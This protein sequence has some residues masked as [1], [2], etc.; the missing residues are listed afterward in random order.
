MPQFTISTNLKWLRHNASALIGYKNSNPK[1]N[2]AM[3]GRAV[4][5]KLQKVVYY[6]L[7]EIAIKQMPSASKV[8]RKFQ[9][10]AT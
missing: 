1:D 8:G 10:K 6:D 5:I 7:P 3:K 9:F 4:G 2:E